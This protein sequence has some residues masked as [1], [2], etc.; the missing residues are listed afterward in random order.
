MNEEK[1]KYQQFEFTGYIYKRNDNKWGTDIRL[2][3]L[4]DETGEKWPQHIL[5]SVSKKNIDK[6]SDAGIGDKVKIWLIPS[7]TEGVS[8]KT[9]KA[10]AIN[11]LNL[12]KCQI[13]E[14][15]AIP[16]TDEDDVGADDMPF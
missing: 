12:Q 1:M 9:Q 3:T 13:L 7:L 16:Q 11:K 6:L 10:Y 14:R 5:V 15:A 4:L 2:R 8:E